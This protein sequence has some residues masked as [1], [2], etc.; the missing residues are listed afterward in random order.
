MEVN[1]ENEISKNE[2]ADRKRKLSN[3]TC[4]SDELNEQKEN[5]VKKKKM[6]RWSSKETLYL[7]YLVHKVG[8]SWVEILSNY[9]KY[10]ENRTAQDLCNKYVKLEKDTLL[11]EQL[12]KKGEI[13]LKDEIKELAKKTINY[14]KW[15]DDEVICLIKGVELFGRN[16]N[17][18]LNEYKNKFKQHRECKGLHS[19]YKCLENNKESLEYFKKLAGII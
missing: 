5:Q 3:D 7:V 4:S 12:R 19:K 8:R 11:L 18:I 17:F 16:W 9:E 1:N 14:G 2:N 10:F 6:N 13:L 15:D